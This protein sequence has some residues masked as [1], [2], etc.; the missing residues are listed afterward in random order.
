MLLIPRLFLW[1]WVLGLSGSRL[2]WRGV[3]GGEA[4]LA[5]SSEEWFCE[6]LGSGLGEKLV[7]TT[8]VDGG[9]LGEKSPKA[10]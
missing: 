10:M 4:G 9:R 6:V 2:R 3:G 7:K 1:G 5:R 8:W